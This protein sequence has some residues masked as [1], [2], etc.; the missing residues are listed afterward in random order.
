MD[1]SDNQIERLLSER[2]L[3][4]FFERVVASCPEKPPREIAA[5][6]LKAFD[7][8]EEFKRSC[9]FRR[10]YESYPERDLYLSRKAQEIRTKLDAAPL[11]LTEAEKRIVKEAAENTTEVSENSANSLVGELLKNPAMGRK[12]KE[13]KQEILNLFNSR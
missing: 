11:E 8:D 10:Y 7:A 3:G 13:I 1:L 4:E 12:P 5:L 9:G 2:Y 6:V